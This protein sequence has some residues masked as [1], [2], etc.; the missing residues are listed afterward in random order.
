LGRQTS[1]AQATLRQMQKAMRL[2]R[3]T[4]RYGWL[5]EG[6]GS[7]TASV[8]RWPVS[9]VACLKRCASRRQQQPMTRARQVAS[10]GLRKEWSSRP[11]KA[12][13][14]RQTGWR[15]RLAN[16]ERGWPL[17]RWDSWCVDGPW[18]WGVVGDLGRNRAADSRASRG[19][20]RRG[21]KPPRCVPTRCRLDRVDGRCGWVCGSSPVRNRIKSQILVLSFSKP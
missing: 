11:P 20:E 12:C 8:E 21:N 3:H 4:L 2:A 15:R 19:R 17:S 16:G 13:T 10:R 1:G 6:D 7:E 9:C 14:A 18:S 5:R